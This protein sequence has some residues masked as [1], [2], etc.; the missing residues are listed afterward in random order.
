VIEMPWVRFGRVRTIECLRCGHIWQELAHRPIWDGLIRQI[1][2]AIL[3][4]GKC[5]WCRATVES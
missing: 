4:P 5:K 2:V 3:P 1:G